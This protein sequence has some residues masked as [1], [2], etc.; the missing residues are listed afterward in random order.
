MVG[1]AIVSGDPNLYPPG[2][3]FPK[4]LNEVGF[5]DAAAGNYR[6]A[7]SSRLRK[8]GSDGGDIGVDFDALP[9]AQS[10]FGPT[11]ARLHDARGHAVVDQLDRAE[12]RPRLAEQLRA[13][14]DPS[15][16]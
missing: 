5:I 11:R 14:N 8:A 7:S 15:A 12:P 16:M 13:K 1:N 4:T 10:V 6:L 3:F 9:A 2:N